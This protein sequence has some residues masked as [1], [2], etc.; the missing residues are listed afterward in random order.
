MTP[1]IEI[2][3]LSK[4]FRTFGSFTKPVERITVLDQISLTVNRGEIFALLGPNGA[5]KTTLI[6]TLCTLIL[7]DEGEARIFGHDLSK[8]SDAVK[9]CINLVVGEERSFY[10]RL[11]GRQ[12]LEFFAA[13]YGL[14]GKEAENR[15]QDAAEIF[16]MDYLDRRYQEYSTGMKQRLAFARCLLNDAEL[17]FMDEPTRSLDPAAALNLK[18]LIKCFAKEKK[19]TIFFATHRLEEIDDLADT[20]AIL[21]KGKI[22]LHSSVP[23][24]KKS[25][26]VSNLKPWL[27]NYFCQPTESSH[28]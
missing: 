20:V 11:T 1:A 12:N 15:I 26:E 5:G 9:Q 2:K 23:E 13:L 8:E 10:W 21:Q 18:A 28:D 24:L 27:E 3:N 16:E 25:L 17:I 7:P 6:K 19:R 4:H 22:K 14:Y